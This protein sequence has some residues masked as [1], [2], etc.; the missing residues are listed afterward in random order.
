[1][2]PN[3]WTLVQDARK[4]TMLRFE[5]AEHYRYGLPVFVMVMVA[6]GCVNLAGITPLLGNSAQTIFFA[7]LMAVT[8]WLVLTRVAAEILR[9]NRNAPRIPFLGY[10][11]MTEAMVIPNVLLFYVSELTM[12]LM[13]WNAW[14]F[15]VQAIGFYHISQQKWTKILWVYLIYWV[16][17][18][19]L[20]ALFLMMLV[21]AGW[22]DINEIKANFDQLMNTMNQHQTKP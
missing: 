16:G 12:V 22:F 6:V 17:S 13:F 11:L 20:L 15:W 3:L 2:N 14:I 10:T 19:L 7:I 21:Q 8:R 9:P 5:P 18:V 4:V 1:M